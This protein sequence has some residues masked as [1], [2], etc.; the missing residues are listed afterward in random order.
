MITLAVSVAMVL[1]AFLFANAA[2]HGRPEMWTL[3]GLPIVILGL[4]WALRP[5]GYSLEGRTLIVHRALG[6]PVRIP[7]H[8][9]AQPQ[10]LDAKELGFGLRV[11]GSGGFGGYYGRFQYAKLGAVRVF[12]T[13]LKKRVLLRAA[14]NR[15]VIISPDDAA[16]FGAALAAAR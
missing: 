7:L 10:P 11:L 14:N 15:A 3:I 6:S 1:P 16:R 12:V 2:L 13:D 4:A 5:T 9:D 8:P